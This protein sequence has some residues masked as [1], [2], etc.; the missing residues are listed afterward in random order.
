MHDNRIDAALG[1]HPTTTLQQPVPYSPVH[2][3]RFSDGPD[4]MVRNPAV[5]TRT[6][7]W[8]RIRQALDL[9]TGLAALVATGLIIVALADHTLPGRVGYAAAGVLVLITCGLLAS[10]HALRAITHHEHRPEKSCRLDRRSGEFFHRC[11][12]FDAV[13]AARVHSLLIT[14]HE[15]HRTPSRAWIGSGVL[16]QA[17]QLVWQA[18]RWADH[19]SHVRALAEE[20]ASTPAT[21]DELGRLG[22]WARRAVLTLDENLS[23]VS[24]DLDGCVTLTRAWERQ[25]Q[26]HELAARADRTLAA[27]PTV[28]ELHRLHAATNALQESTFAYITAARDVT[29]DDRF[30][31][32]LSA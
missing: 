8:I 25:L 24:D 2:M 17:H 15:L 19:T 26:Q 21:C 30:P 20:L 1:R 13:T 28:A 9:P 32:E 5:S 3:G 22:A 11:R 16:R 18:V 27:L 29:G 7:R 31:W 23:Q 6:W 14:L 12:D 4:L 10:W